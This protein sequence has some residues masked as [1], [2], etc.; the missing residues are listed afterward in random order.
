MKKILCCFLIPAMIMTSTP[1]FAQDR[2]E[3]DAN[4]LQAVVSLLSKLIHL[5]F[6]SILLEVEEDTDPGLPGDSMGDESS[7]PPIP[8][9]PYKEEDEDG[10]IPFSLK[11]KGIISMYTTGFF[12]KKM[13]W[14][15]KTRALGT[16]TSA[17]IHCKTLTGKI[18]EVGVTLEIDSFFHDNWKHAKGEF[19]EPDLGNDCGWESFEQIVLALEL[20]KGVIMINTEDKPDGAISGDIVNIG[21]Y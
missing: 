10:G 7:G 13:K 21:L 11:P 2:E 16:V 6:T 9:L 17:Y 5:R 12:S 19:S 8:G 3:G 20:G 4:T 15:I 18:G 14:E 1:V